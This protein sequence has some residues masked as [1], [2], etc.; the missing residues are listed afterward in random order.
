MQKKSARKTPEPVKNQPVVST[1]VPDKIIFIVLGLLAFFLYANSIN[2]DYTVDDATVFKN[3]KYTKEGISA[4][5][6]IISSPYRAGFWSRNEGLYRP[7]SPVMFA[8]EWEL[9]PEKPWVSHLVNVILYMITAALL[10][11]VLRRL[12]K[13]THPLIPLIAT[14]LFIV[15]PVHTEV[16]A[17]IKSRDEILGFLFG[18]FA[19]YALLIYQE[20]NKMQWMIISVVAYFLCL[21]SKESSVTWLG[22]FP[23]VMWCS[24]NSDL[25][26]TFMITLPYIVAAALFLFIRYKIL[27][28]AGA[29]FGQM[30]INNSLL[31]TSKEGERIATAVYI[32][33]KYLWLLCFPVVLVFDYS[34]NTIPIVKFTSIQALIPLLIYAG[35]FIYAMR[36]LKNRSMISFGILL[37]IGTI[38][39]VANILFLIEATMAERFLYTP[40]LGYCIVFAIL[41]SSLLVKKSDNKPGKLSIAHFK[42]NS[43]LIIPFL[44]VFFLYSYKTISRNSEWKDNLT[45]LQQDIKSS[46]NSARVC[47]AYGSAILIEQALKEK[48]RTEKARMLDESIDYL[49]K[50]V[51]LIPDY[52]DAWYHLGIAYK[53]KEDAKS[54]IYA[55]EQARSWKPF[56]EAGKFTSAGIA[57]GMAGMYDKA[58][59]DLKKAV[60]LDPT[61]ADYYNNLG[62]Y[63]SEAGKHDEAMQAFERALQLNDRFDKVFYNR[64]NAWAKIGQYRNAIP[65][66]K[67]ALELH[68]GYSDALN[69]IGNCYAAMSLPDSAA[70]WFQKAVDADEYNTKAMINLG[71]TYTMLGD[72]AKGKLY[73]NKARAMGAQF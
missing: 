26:K 41:I 20:K 52:N 7:L 34:Y 47:F 62:L 10:Y 4:I 6:K 55:F 46:P 54:A 64:G 69:N 12:L 61:S 70:P 36:N 71:V 21:F 57:Y 59:P 37:F 31:A 49:K 50:G 58:I 45:L 42:N 9:A 3:N 13:S 15:L 67:K 72:S 35:A 60:E 68:P 33:G 11:A 43:K 51:E 63:L 40:S 19:V 5:P 66:Y 65:D 53:E 39:I 25:K 27:G 56:D 23:L 32:L 22:V 48:D 16:V 8:I 17:N 30:L 1:P 38:S 29:N 2:H 44:I 28:M 18:L 24:L 14:L 73:I